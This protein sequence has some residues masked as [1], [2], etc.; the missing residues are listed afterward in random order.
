MASSKS[1]RRFG[2]ENAWNWSLGGR[3]ATL[4]Q[5]ELGRVRASEGRWTAAGREEVESV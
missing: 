3:W 1:P 4:G 2:G 5:E